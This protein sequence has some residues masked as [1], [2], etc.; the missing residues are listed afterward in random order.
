MPGPLEDELGDV[1]EKSRDGKGWTQSDLAHAAGVSASDISRMERY[2]YVPDESVLKKLAKVL[3]LHA[4][5]L[6]AVA[7][8]TWSP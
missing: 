7:K 1:L 5:S 4:P 2:E 8:E 3:D 6:I